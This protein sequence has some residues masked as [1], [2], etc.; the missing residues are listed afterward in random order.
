MIEIK[1]GFN[2]DAIL[3]QLYKLTKIEDN[4][5][6]NAVALVDGQP[7]TL[8]LRDMLTVYLEHRYEVT[9]RRT[10]FAGPRRG[11]AFTWSKVC[12]WR[13]SISMTSSP[14]SAHLTTPPRPAR[15]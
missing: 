6:I 12:W 2:P 7:R 5:A 13:S 3:E 15:G 4:Y 9:R 11:S 14:S 1:S 8:T 10:E